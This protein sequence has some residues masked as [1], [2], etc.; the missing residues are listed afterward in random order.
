MRK[1]VISLVQQLLAVHSD[2]INVGLNW[3]SVEFFD[4]LISWISWPSWGLGGSGWSNCVL[5]HVLLG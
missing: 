3:S 4:F 1:A 2:T 5:M